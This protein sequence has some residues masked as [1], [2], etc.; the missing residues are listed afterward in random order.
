MVRH[1]LQEVRF[2]ALEL[3]FGALMRGDCLLRESG[4]SEWFRSVAS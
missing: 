2:V 1:P 4:H 3:L